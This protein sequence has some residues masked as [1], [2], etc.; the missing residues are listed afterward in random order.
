MRKPAT[1]ENRFS[2]HRVLIGLVLVILLPGS[3]LRPAAFAQAPA[4]D[5]YEPDDPNAPWIGL[6][7]A[8]ERSFYPEGD[9]DRA[10]LRVKAGRW[11][12]VRTQDLAPLVDTVLTVDLGGATLEDDDGGPEPLASRVTFQAP[13]TAE[14]L[15]TIV[16]GQAVYSTTQTYRLYAAEL[17]APTL[18][19]TWTPTPTETPS[20]TPTAT[21]T[22]TPRPTEPPRLTDVPPR[23]IV[24]FSATPDRVEAPGQCVTL[25][26]SVER[27]SEVYLV[28]PN[29]NRQGVTGRE[30]RQVC[31]LETSTYRLEVHAPG[32]DET[33][34][35]QVAVPLPTHT[36]TPK[37]APGGSGSSGVG[38]SAAAGKSTVHVAVFVDENGSG[39]Y[40]P[41]EGVLGAV[42]T[43]MSQA[44]PGRSWTATTDAQG[45][46]RFEAAPAG[47]YTLLIP[48]LSHA[49]AV[50]VRGD[51]LTVA[52]LVAPL[53][54]P[55]R[56]P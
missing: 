33:V 2:G 21:P 56:I 25:S 40:D 5:A 23:P 7:E 31:P 43:L 55:A 22:A 16:T 27:A 11:Y 35:V 26:W 20:P 54:L 4:P 13:E 12:E 1:F 9:V 49:E 18:T 53:Q 38:S 17:P 42:V 50:S 3:V 24:S 36:P 51:E 46:V 45:R 14:A 52:V 39:A 37:P 15:I 29:G 41:Q 28:E 8:Q 30:E 10:R 47:S 34:E 19:P 44:D 48:Y 32:G 6:D